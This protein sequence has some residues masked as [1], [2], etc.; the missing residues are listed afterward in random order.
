M[1][2][3]GQIP[4]NLI[5]RFTELSKTEIIVLS[6]L[7]ASRNKNGQ[8]NPSRGA[9]SRA[10]GIAKPHVSTAVKSLDSK[11][12]ICELPVGGFL[13]TE[14]DERVTELVTPKVTESVTGGLRISTTGVTDFDERVTDSVT[15]LNKESEHIEHKG[16]H[17]G[18]PDDSTAKE[19][20]ILQTET[21]LNLK[22]FLAEKQ[23]IYESI[24]TQ[25]TK[26]WILYLKA[27]SL[28][29]DKNANRTEIIRQLGYALTDFRRDHKKE[30]EAL[31]RTEQKLPTL[32]EKL[33]EEERRRK[34][35]PRNHPPQLVSG[36]Q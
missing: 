6:F 25:F 24:P 23:T 33:A 4:T 27:R 17:R 14:P 28:K 3:F 35:E 32:A 22:L 15:L 18:T 31:N 8:C 30:Y 13:L 26:D 34:E 19:L 7:Y 12:W 2:K 10:T 9:V 16:E 36:V 29:I 5:C 1:S 20:L 11:G 21:V